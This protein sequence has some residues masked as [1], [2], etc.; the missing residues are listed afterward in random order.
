MRGI[1]FII[2]IATRVVVTAF[3]DEHDEIKRLLLAEEGG[4]IEALAKINLGFPDVDTWIV[5]REDGYTHIYSVDGE[6]NIRYVTL[7]ATVEQSEVRYW[8]TNIQSNVDL[9]FDIMQ[10]IPG[11]R[12]GSKAVA[13]GD[14]NDDGIDEIFIIIPYNESRC[15]I[16]RICE[17]GEKELYFAS[18]FNITEPKGPPPVVFINYQGLDGIK[19]NVWDYPTKRYVWDFYAWSK[20][21]NKFVIIAEDI[22]ER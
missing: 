16:W 12:L 11:T 1:I 14:Y 17:N 7:I 3:A 22:G 15:N 4:N 5:N 18:R 21:N 13:F 19:V 2:Y 9:E 20:M 8:D 10:N 6:K